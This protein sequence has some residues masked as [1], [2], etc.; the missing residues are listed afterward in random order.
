MTLLVIGPLW[1]INDVSKLSLSLFLARIYVWLSGNG[2]YIF[3]L[4]V[5]SYSSNL[6]YII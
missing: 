1:N 6:F 2:D 5:S 4:K 3:F